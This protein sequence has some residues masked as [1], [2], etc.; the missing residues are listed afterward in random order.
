[1]TKTIVALGFL[2]LNFYIY[3]W[4]AT[5][6]VVPPRRA[7]AEFPLQLGEWACPRRYVM[8]DKTLAN[9]GASDYLIC[10]FQ[11][12]DPPAVVE[13]YVGYHETQVRREGGGGAGE[14]S[15]HPPKHCLPGSG[16]DIIGHQIVSIDL[17]GLPQPSPQVNRLLIAKG[18]ARQVVYYWY[19]TQGR[20]IADDWKKIL[21][22]SWDRARSS[23]TDG[24]L[25]RFTAPI[26]RQDEERADR[27]ILELAG[28]IAPDLGAYVPE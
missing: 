1:M 3:H 13:V 4:F 26:H 27:E 2:A 8:D 7:F 18:Q 6:E 19:Q 21:Y 5:E 22:L 28:L 20:V 24:A 16:W 12:R 9:L 11:R 25:V 10:E 23:R 14:N 17:P 15:I